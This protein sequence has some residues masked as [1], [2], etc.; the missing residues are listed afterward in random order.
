MAAGIRAKLEMGEDG[1]GAGGI[2]N[3]L[4]AQK[5]LD[6]RAS[7]TGA[8]LDTLYDSDAMPPSL[9]NVHAKLDKAVDRLYR[10]KHFG[11][12]RERVEHLFQ[13]YQ[14]ASAPLVS[15]AKKASK[16]NK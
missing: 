12:E 1:R 13:L 14:E 3:S 11:F 15:A 6:T 7:F 2:F 4:L 5:I 8:S 10:R 9:R 16:R